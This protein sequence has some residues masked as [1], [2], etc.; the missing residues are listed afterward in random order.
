M[1]ESKLIIVSNRLPVQLANNNGKTEFVPSSGGL[2]SSIKSYLDSLRTVESSQKVK[3]IGTLD[4][5][6]K[7]FKKNKLEH[8]LTSGEFDLHPVFLRAS[9][10]EKFYNGFCNDTIWPLF[11]YFPSYAK[12]RGDYF[13]SYEIANQ[14]FCDAI[15]SAYQPEDTIWIHDY[16]LMLL[17]AMLRKQLPEAKIGFFLHIPF[18]S[19]EVFRMLPGAWRLQILEGLL[20]A[21]LIGFHT[22]S[23]AQYFLSSVNKLAGHETSPHRVLTTERTVAVDV[24]PVSIDF[25]S[26][27]SIISNP[28]I[29]EERNRIKKQLNDVKLIISVDRLDYTK[30]IINRLE[31]FELLL[32]RHQEYIG[33]IT[34][35]IVTV[36]S[37]DIIAK[38]KELKENIEAL[39]GRIN[40]R[41]GNLE[42][43][44]VIYQY[45]SIDFKTL[46]ALYAAADVA[47]ITPIRDGMNLVAKEFVASRSD[48]RG[49]LILSE[50]A[51]AAT[52]LG[53]ALLINPTDRD[54]VADA[55]VQALNM[56]VAEQMTRNELMQ[57]RLKNYDVV[58]WATE[59]LERLELSLS[60][61][62]NLKVKVLRLKNEEVIVNQ[63]N[64]SGRRL[65][66]LDY[67]GTLAPI[68]RFPHLAEPHP[69]LMA[70][71]TLLCRD[72]DNRI[73]I[74]SG[75]PKSD[76]EKWFGAKRIDLIAEHGA[77]FKRH[78]SGWIRIPEAIAAWKSVVDPVMQIFTERCPGSFIEEKE[79]S[80]AWHY[81][82]ADSDLGFLRSREL[83]GRL[84]A[85]A[86]HHP[87]QVIEG[88]KVVEVRPSGVDKGTAAV[89]LLAEHKYDFI[90]A[91][92]DD[93]TDEDLFRVLPDDAVSIRV[94]LVQSQA[95]FNVG[96]QHE[97][98]K[99]LRKFSLREIATVN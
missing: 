29:F 12:F 44:P 79:F 41:Y 73:V 87:F 15:V 98:I 14:Q 92:G 45:K 50:T 11:H 42:W 1:M 62:Q 57:K 77:Y 76:L 40:G 83:I 52:E 63:F 82:N 90:F 26:F 84:H 60:D 59:Y 80:L 28:E 22:H 33:K 46:G 93:R 27:N 55:L 68:A 31:G 37:R 4:I 49:V 74:I 66:L 85:L 51:G 25:A 7:R 19:F 48:R 16:H 18:P 21:D 30:G 39:V 10:R 6:E 2:V 34:F 61:Q 35:M 3:W 78:E 70:L 56:P 67:D 99:L 8:S 43:T 13:K 91:A 58:K 97:V 53:E 5:S 9:T 32:Q 71:I 38:Y 47:L 24:F 54:E 23:Y 94:G 81:R 75:R 20:G 36:P 69:E 88:K 72:P 86:P 96:L 65:L 17:P 64:N 89:S 95:K